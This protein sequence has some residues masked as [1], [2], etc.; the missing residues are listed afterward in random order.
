MRKKPPRR[1]ARQNRPDDVSIGRRKLL[2]AL[3]AST[4][5]ILAAGGVAHAAVRPP[6]AVD[7]FEPIDVQAA[8]GDAAANFAFEVPRRV[9]DW[10]PA[11]PATL[12]RRWESMGLD[13]IADLNAVGD[14]ASPDADTAAFLEY[15]EAT[16]QRATNLHV[17]PGSF[18]LNR[19]VELREHRNLVIAGA[20]GGNAVHAG[21]LVQYVGNDPRGFFDL[22]TCVDVTFAGIAWVLGVPGVSHHF[23][24]GALERPALSSLHIN[25]EDCSFA[26]APGCSPVFAAVWARNAIYVTFRRPTF[27]QANTAILLGDTT[28]ADNGVASGYVGR[29]LIEEAHLT[30]DI[31][32]RRASGVGLYGGALLENWDDGNVTRGSKIFDDSESS[33]TVGLVLD[34][35]NLFGRWNVEN[36]TDSAIELDA[37][38]T[39]VRVANCHINNYLTGLD[40]SGPGGDSIAFLENYLDQ[41]NVDGKPAGVRLRPGFAGRLR[42]ENNHLTKQMTALEGVELSDER[43]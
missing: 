17:P 25:F 10:T 34:R 23:L 2:A 4:F 27:A 24:I 13:L 9:L 35:V 6:S 16:K 20:A 7:P 21:S 29:V 18:R 28:N 8:T 3:P 32:L 11:A 37:E 1:P 15:A 12:R 22:K 42:V 38:Y 36:L 33:S 19:T 40:L 30:G 5:G 26:A 39:S 14:D 31:R 41:A 43:S